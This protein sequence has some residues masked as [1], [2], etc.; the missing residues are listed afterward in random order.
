MPSHKFRKMLRRD[1]EL[2]EERALLA[3]LAGDAGAAFEPNDTLD[4]AADLGLIGSGVFTSGQIVQVDARIGTYANDTVG[5][6]SDV[7][8]Y[9]VDLRAGDIVTFDI[10]AQQLADG[11][12]LFDPEAGGNS[13][14]SNNVLRLFNREASGLGEYT[15]L[16]SATG[17]AESNID[18]IISDYV[19]PATGTY[20]IG[21]SGAVE[22]G[23]DYNPLDATGRAGTVHTGQYILKV[24]TVDD[25]VDRPDVNVVVPPNTDAGDNTVSWQ[26]VDDSGISVSNV[27]VWK[28]G[29]LIVPQRPIPLSGAIDLDG[30]G[31]GDYRMDIVATDNDQDW[32]PGDRLTNNF[33]ILFNISDD[34]IDPPAITITAPQRLDGETNIVSWEVVDQSPLEEVLAEIWKG[35][36]QIFSGNV[37]AVSS[38]NLDTSGVG[39][40]RIT[41]NATDDDKDSGL[42]DQLS[43]ESTLE[44]RILDDDTTPPVVLLNTP[45][46]D[47]GQDNVA[48]WEVRDTSAASVVNVVVTKA[49]QSVFDSESQDLTGEFDLN[50]LGPGDYEVT[51]SA[52]DGDS[53]WVGDEL[54]ASPTS[55]SFSI[56][57]DDEVPPSISLIPPSTNDGAANILRWEI[58]DFSGIDLDSV[59]AEIIH[60]G[61]SIFNERVDPQGS[62]SL[63]AEGIGA[64]E[65]IVTAKDADN[66][67]NNDQLQSTETIS[68][69]IADDDT[70]E[71]EIGIVAPAEFDRSEN[72]VRWTVS[73]TSG[74]KEVTVAISQ[75]GVSIFNQELQGSGTFD[76]DQAGPGAYAI[77]VSAIDA[78]EDWDGDST[79]ATVSQEFTIAD[80]DTAAPEI[81]ITGP[82]D[83]DGSD[84]VIFWDVQ[85]ASGLDVID[86]T[87]SK[88]G[89]AV[90]NLDGNAPSSGSYD[91]NSLGLGTYAIEIFARDADTNWPGDS[92]STTQTAEFVVTDDDDAAPMVE[93]TVPG[94]SADGADNRVSWVVTDPSGV[95]SVSAEVLRNDVRIIEGPIAFPDA[96][97]L[98]SF[99]PG[100]YSI[101]IVATDADDDWS[102]IG[103]TDSRTS[104]T[105]AQFTIT[106]DDV[107]APVIN[108]DTGDDSDGSNNVLAWTVD[109]ASGAEVSVVIEK[110][111]Q[112]INAGSGSSESFDFNAFGVGDYSVTITATDNDTDWQDDQ[113]SSQQIVEFSIVDDDTTPPVIEIQADDSLDGEDTFLTWRVSD[114]SGLNGLI[115]V[116]IWKD[117]EPIPIAVF[118]NEGGTSLNTYGPGN[119][120]ITVSGEDGDNDWEGDSLSST[121]TRNFV[122][123]DDDTEPPVISIDPASGALQGPDGDN[124]FG[125]TVNDVDSGIGNGFV[126][127]EREAADGSFERLDQRTF[128][129][130]DT[131]K[132]V[133]GEVSV[134]DF[135]LGVYRLTVTASDAD[136]DF[137]NDVLTAQATSILEVA[138][139][140]APGVVSAGEAVRVSYEQLGTVRFEFSEDVSASLDSGDVTLRNLA[141][142]EVLAISQEF[143]WDAA[144]LTASLDLSGLG[145]LSKAMYGVEL[146][147]DGITDAAGNNLDGDGDGQAGGDFLAQFPVTW[148]GDA[149]RDVDV[150]FLDFLTIAENF[151]KQGGWAEG[152][153]GGSDEVDF[154][155][156]LCLAN[157]FGIQVGEERPFGC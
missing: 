39:D 151:L 99:G 144:T 13:S 26:I 23:N 70:A 79:A 97:D 50:G 87:I 139:T 137:A 119:F 157:N 78:D 64:Y 149:D 40:Y 8:I 146:D 141:T 10:D 3:V 76:L 48:S 114:E 131:Q 41:I 133:S 142:D 54:D 105:T 118:A 94:D 65:V 128:E 82:N 84:N 110:D 95:R 2:L 7:D 93:I 104:L 130:N 148:K 35:E 143:S 100:E 138:D 58:T 62:F 16:A 153:F 5:N 45:N 75:D 25:D 46:G 136:R 32:G 28:D 91:V 125:W 61:V 102:V 116:N 14:N 6:S 132:T 15:L 51:V 30:Y 27:Q 85:D 122:V 21:V 24:T 60:D 20:F 4:E 88:D 57:D 52:T 92:Q 34:D 106:D 68:F 121:A 124:T 36:E 83:T 96:F 81:M 74:L 145:Q 37:D 150:D 111:G 67:W 113:L 120:Q 89:V 77:T 98:N 42:S 69:M 55:I 129:F 53:D 56:I 72:V 117:G 115:D 59:N 38:Y 12:S 31:H 112:S 109:D 103:E 71:P 90:L 29:E 18:P 127:L 126:R 80:D 44:F 11:D 135:G 134:K 147:S 19:V 155:D 101:T 49:G 1:F 152:N 156:Y 107:E 123:S 9:Q 86:V 108:V 22:S 17:N 154:L 43:S 66:D 63:D 47:D 73:D 140:T 33:S